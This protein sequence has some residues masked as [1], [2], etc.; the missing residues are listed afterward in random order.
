MRKFMEGSEYSEVTDDGL[1]SDYK[2]S[3]KKNRINQSRVPKNL[4]VLG[5]TQSILFL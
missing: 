5:H 3:S 1:P 4:P 2:H